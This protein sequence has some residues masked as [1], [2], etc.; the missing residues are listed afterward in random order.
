MR[1]L[2]FLVL[3]PLSILIL[4]DASLH[5]KYL[6]GLEGPLPFELETGYVSVGESGDVELFYYFVKSERNPDKDPLMIWLTGG[7]GCSS[8]CGFL[9]AN[10]KQILFFLGFI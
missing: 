3:F 10:G 2:Y 5:V 6:P 9:F 4:V 1:N 7:P 8:I